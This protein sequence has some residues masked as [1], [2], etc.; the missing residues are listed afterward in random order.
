MRHRLLEDSL[1]VAEQQVGL[2][3][4]WRVKDIDSSPDKPWTTMTCHSF[5]S[6]IMACDGSREV[7]MYD[8]GS[9]K[10]TGSINLDVVP[11]HQPQPH[12][13]SGAS[14]TSARFVNELHEQIVIVAEVN[15]GD[16]HILAGSQEPGTIKPI[17]CFHALDLNFDIDP[18]LWQHIPGTGVSGTL[19]TSILPLVGRG[20]R[21]AS[22]KPKSPKSKSMSESAVAVKSDRPRGQKRMVNTWFRSSGLLCVGGESDKI[23]V[24]DCPAERCVK[25]VYTY[26]DY[27]QD[28]LGLGLGPGL[29]LWLGQSRASVTTLI[30]EPVSGNLI[31]AGSSDGTL[32]LYDLRQ[33]RKTAL[34]TWRGDVGNASQ[35]QVG[36]SPSTSP[37][38]LDGQASASA[39]NLGRAMKKVGVVLGESKNITSACANGIINTHDLRKLSE[40][41]SSILAH[42]DGI[43]AASFQGHSGLLSTV[44]NLNTNSIPL[45]SGQGP[46]HRDRAVEVEVEWAIHRSALGQLGQVTKETITFPS[47]AGSPTSTST[48]A[49]TSDVSIASSTLDSDSSQIVKDLHVDAHYS[50]YTVFHPLRPFVSIGHGNTCYLRGCGVG[51]GADTDS[52]SY[53]FLR[54]QAD[55]GESDTSTA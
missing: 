14:V 19:F 9:G 39:K 20:G 17:A 28:G 3:W 29:G 32:K 37:S 48:S 30:T 40:P 13:G 33:A 18:T 36:H 52:G 8:W 49:S 22:S 46:S 7:S 23:N 10:K 54:A 5:H 43:A 12:G 50:P 15:D 16:I 6:I 21:Y 35:S 24:W 55:L 26:S 38:S 11:T 47:S 34:L 51:Q 31:F 1:V 44:S 4:K 25:T 45:P 41:V 2:P 42:K 53:S 27:A